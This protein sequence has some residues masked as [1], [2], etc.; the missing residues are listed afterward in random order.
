[1]SLV[2]FRFFTLFTIVNIIIT[3]FI[4]DSAIIR[5]R[6]FIFFLKLSYEM[7]QLI[8]KQFYFFRS[9]KITCKQLVSRIHDKFFKGVLLQI[10]WKEISWKKLLYSESNW[11]KERWR[12]VS[13]GREHPLPTVTIICLSKIYWEKYSYSYIYTAKKLFVGKWENYRGKWSRTKKTT[14]KGD[15]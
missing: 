4:S 8:C 11:M 6:I 7:D 14:L 13:I 1:M 12:K 9:L 5:K 15:T 10:T 3:I 2:I